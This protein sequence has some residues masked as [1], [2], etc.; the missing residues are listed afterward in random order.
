MGTIFSRL[1]FKLSKLISPLLVGSVG[2]E[3]SRHS[4]EYRA[5]EAYAPE[6][7]RIEVKLQRS[8]KSRKREGK[9]MGMESRMPIFA[10]LNC[11]QTCRS[12]PALLPLFSPLFLWVRL[13]CFSTQAASKVV[14]CFRVVRTSALSWELLVAVP[15]AAFCAGGGVDVFSFPLQ[16]LLCQRREVVNENTGGDWHKNSCYACLF[17]F[18]GSTPFLVL[19]RLC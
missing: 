3:G 16:Y 10:Q 13:P 12:V 11:K 2:R 4:Q 5:G 15:A 6:R 1:L 14:V 17:G 9:G 18:Q 19:P 8:G 7:P